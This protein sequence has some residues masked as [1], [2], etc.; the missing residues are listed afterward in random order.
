METSLYGISTRK[1][2][3]RSFKLWSKFTR[4]SKYDSKLCRPSYPLNFWVP[5][6]IALF[7]KR[8]KYVPPISINDLEKDLPLL[9]SFISYLWTYRPKIDK[10]FMNLVYVNKNCNRWNNCKNS[11]Q[12]SMNILSKCF[13]EGL[14]NNL[15][16]LQLTYQC[17]DSILTAIGRHSKYLKILD[18]S[19]SSTITINGIKSFIFKNLNTFQND[20]LNGSEVQ[21][22]AFLKSII[23]N[24]EILNTI[25]F[26]LEEI[27]LQYNKTNN[28]GWILIISCIQSLRHL[29]WPGKWNI[30]KIIMTVWHE[31]IKPKTFNLQSITLVDWD[32][33]CEEV[34]MMTECLP[35]LRNLNTTLTRSYEPL[36]SIN[37]QLLI[38]FWNKLNSL[39]LYIENSIEYF[40]LFCRNGYVQNL[41]E[42]TIKSVSLDISVDLA[43][44]QSGCPNLIIL[45]IVSILLYINLK[46]TGKFK[47]LKKVTT[48]APSAETKSWF[49]FYGCPSLEEFQIYNEVDPEYWK[50]IFINPPPLI[51]QQMKRLQIVFV[52]SNENTDFLIQPYVMNYSIITEFIR[53]C[54]VLNI[55]G[56]ILNFNMSAQDIENIYSFIRMNNYSLTIY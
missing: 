26:T 49:L 10:L 39:T 37:H 19:C 53:K 15:V 30:K 32:I 56:S 6:S 9:L 27:R 25:C 38:K 52:L 7:D 55:F 35:N 54:L 24:R 23:E 3:N 22:Y 51:C 21:I 42:L 29:G 16:Q 47:Y 36:N 5:F 48:E 43:L 44:L 18:V 13:D 45:D 41:S 4:F 34:Y 12:L 8:I 40:E 2:K 14:A 50:N 20:M 33:A 28:L 11:I 17:D 46:P 31:I 1:F